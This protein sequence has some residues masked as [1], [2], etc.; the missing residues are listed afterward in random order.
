MPAAQLCALVPSKSSF[1]LWHGTLLLL[2]VGL[3][4]NFL[5]NFPVEGFQELILFLNHFEHLV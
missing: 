2:L 1:N 3:L 5:F 4:L